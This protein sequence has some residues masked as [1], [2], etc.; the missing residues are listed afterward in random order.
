MPNTQDLE[1]AATA[2]KVVRDLC[3]V[4]KGESLLITIDSAGFWPL[5][6]ETAKAGEALGAKVMVAWHSTPPGYGRAGD[7]YLP[8]ALHAAI[9]NTDVWIEY[10]Y[11]W[12]LYST[13]WEKAVKSGR[14]RYL[15]LGGLNADQI[16][17]T[18]GKVDLELQEGFQNLLVEMT[19]KAKTMRI[20]TP[21]G[22]DL[23]FQN[24]PGRPINSEGWAKKPGATTFLLGQIGWA[25]N[26]GT[27][28]GTMIFDGS[29]SG[30]G[31]AE[32]GRLKTPICLT[33]KKGR[34][35]SFSGGEEAKFIEGW[36]QRLGDPKMYDIAH[37][38]Y[39]FNPGAR[40]TG[41][42]TEDERVWGTTEWGFGNQGPNYHGTRGAA[43]T[44]FDG[45]CLN[46]SVWLDGQQ[47]LDQGIFLEPKLATLA[48][49][50]GKQS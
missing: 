22:T 29:F 37:V 31:E 8:D 19:A 35:Q 28:E 12:L 3:Q 2:Y 32:I 9:P 14:V 18:V 48:K 43:A 27:V 16:I 17:R 47:I 33:I 6:E 5:A 7:P 44:H 10:N 42:C 20:T 38:C 49:K 50:I 36:I 4:K 26:E 23:T 21:A 39:G 40:L 11:Q 24:V 13:P 30:G 15:F 45:T 34:I 1:L 25:P 46:S 41:L